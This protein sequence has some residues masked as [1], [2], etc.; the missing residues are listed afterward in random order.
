[1]PT[2]SSGIASDV[3]ML[4]GAVPVFGH[5][6]RLIRRP[7][8]FLRQAQAYGDVVM[9]R[10]GPT[11]AYYVGQPE[12]LR[13]MLLTG[14]GDYDK[15]VHYDKA[16]VVI[17]NGLPASNGEFHRRQRALVRP[18][19]QKARLRGYFEVMAECTQIRQGSWGAGGGVDIGA[20]MHAL[21]LEIAVRTLTTSDMA[22][23]VAAALA[24]AVS[25]LATGAGRRV[26]DPTGLLQRLPLR[27]NRRFDQARI[28]VRNHFEGLIRDHPSDR[29]KR[30]DL[31]S[32]LLAARAEDG[33]GMSDEQVRDELVSIGLAALETT[34]QTLRW[35]SHLLAEHPVVQDRVRQEI[36]EVTAGG[37][38]RFED[39]ERLAYTRRVL[40]EVLRMYP[41][42]YFLSR[43]P[44]VDVTIGGHTIPAGSMVLFSPYALQRDPTLYPD[45]DR[46]DPDRWLTTEA[47]APQRASYL[48]FGAG[49]RSCIGD[50]FAMTEMLT[51]LATVLPRWTV[52][53]LA[54]IE[55]HPKTTFV[56]AP[57]ATGVAVDPCPA[58]DGSTSGSAVSPLR[59]PVSDAEG[60]R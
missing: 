6:P 54:A 44:T 19:F 50:Q 5:L 51:I 31:L 46:F 45:P 34:A 28:L 4:P 9:V 1:M 49:I 12:H 59:C 3:P 26:I 20:E 16:R 23:D 39:L 56:L 55:V 33:G 53:R 22:D 40:Q 48:A 15:G 38:L 47:D 14:A 25:I 37:A 21:A 30:P 32:V 43:R 2:V 29:V 10:L 36:E 24:R 60:A 42:L 17:G 57:S 11:R 41:P 7:L 27:S 52:R 35:T 13:A 18:A 8:H 58:R